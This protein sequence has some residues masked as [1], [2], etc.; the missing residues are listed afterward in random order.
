MYH[1]VIPT[2]RCYAC[3]QQTQLIYNRLEIQTHFGIR[4]VCLCDECHK[5]QM[6]L[7]TSVPRNGETLTLMFDG[8]QIRATQANMQRLSQITKA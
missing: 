1:K 7:P 8:M 4:R 5:I 6:E 3:K 2:E